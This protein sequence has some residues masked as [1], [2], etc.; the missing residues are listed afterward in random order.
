METIGNGFVVHMHMTRI[1]C[2][3]DGLSTNWWKW[4]QT[5][6]CHGVWIYARSAAAVWRS[7]PSVMWHNCVTSVSDVFVV[8]VCWD[9]VDV[10]N[11]FVGY[12][13]SS[14]TKPLIKTM[15]AFVSHV[16][17]RLVIQLVLCFTF[18]NNFIIFLIVF[19]FFHLFK[20]IYDL[21][22]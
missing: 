21:I 3:C 14:A 8:I 5:K 13:P 17:H 12:V 2:H 9:A 4:D 10:I 15:P 19:T 16:I 1:Q 22:V 18:D 20:C 11:G 7:W 6:W